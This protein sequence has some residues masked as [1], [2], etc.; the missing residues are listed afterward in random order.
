MVRRLLGVP[1]CS[2]IE[3]LQITCSYNLDNIWNPSRPLDSGISRL[4]CLFTVRWRFPDRHLDTRPQL[5]PAVWNHSVQGSRYKETQDHSKRNHYYLLPLGGRRTHKKKM[6]Y[7]IRTL[8]EEGQHLEYRSTEGSLGVFLRRKI[9]KL[10][11]L[12]LLSP[13]PS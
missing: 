6:R 10:L 11:L 5:W 1:S 8:G 3:D 12:M 13:L 7:K 9:C 2:Q 4:H